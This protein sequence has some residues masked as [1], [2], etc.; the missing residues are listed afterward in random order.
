MIDTSAPVR[1]AY[2]TALNGHVT[3]T[4]PAIGDVA[5]GATVIPVYSHVPDAVVYPFIYLGNQSDEGGDV[6]TRTKDNKGATEHLIEIKIVSGFLTSEDNASFKSADDIANEVLKIVLASTPLTFV[7]LG[8]VTTSLE[9]M[10]YD[11]DRNDTHLVI[12]KTIVI[13]HLLDQD[14]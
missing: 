1:T 8:N 12:E 3:V 10:S 4:L 5:A 11:V 7:G 14:Y 9:S 6:E 13:R 2:Y